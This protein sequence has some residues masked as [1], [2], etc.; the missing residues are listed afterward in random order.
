M[1]LVQY[2]LVKKTALKNKGP[3]MRALV[4]GEKKHEKEKHFTVTGLPACEDLILK[5]LAFSLRLRDKR[6]GPD[7][8]LD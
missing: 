7:N 5:L 3:Q 1:K 6:V 8:Y 4:F 2:Y